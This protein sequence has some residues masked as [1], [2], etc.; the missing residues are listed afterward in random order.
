MPSLSFSS[1]GKLLRIIREILFYK[2]CCADQKTFLVCQIEKGHISQY[3]GQIDKF[4]SGHLQVIFSA[5]IFPGV[6]GV[7]YESTIG[8]V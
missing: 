7:I 5:A 6:N 3:Q 4:L 2:R 8:T 1:L